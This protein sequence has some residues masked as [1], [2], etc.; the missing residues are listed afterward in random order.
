MTAFLCLVRSSSR[1]EKKRFR[2]RRPPEDSYEQYREIPV[3]YTK[4]D[5]TYE[6]SALNLWFS[7]AFSKTAKDDTRSTGRDTYKIYMGKTK[8]KIASSF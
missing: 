8:R 5:A 7:H 2:P 6:D 1:A 3:D 4:I